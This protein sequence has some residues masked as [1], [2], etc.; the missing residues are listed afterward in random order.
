MRYSKS[1]RDAACRSAETKGESDMLIV[2]QVLAKKRPSIRLV[3]M[4]PLSRKECEN[5]GGVTVIKAAVTNVLAQ[6]K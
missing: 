6:H 4:A 1:L 2:R 3:V 5:P